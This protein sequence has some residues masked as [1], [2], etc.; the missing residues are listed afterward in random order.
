[1]KTLILLAIVSLSCLSLPSIPTN[2]IPFN[3]IIFFSIYCGPVAEDRDSFLPP[4]GKLEKL[5]WTSY[6]L[7]LNYQVH[8]ISHLI[9]SHWISSLVRCSTN[10]A[11]WDGSYALQNRIFKSMGAVRSE[12]NLLGCDKN[13]LIK[14]VGW[15][16]KGKER[17]QGCLVLWK[18]WFWYVPVCIC[19][20]WN[21]SVWSHI[22]T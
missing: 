16:R 5:T 19:I 9:S 12:I 2:N 1:M 17:E 18:F 4:P 8:W 3:F 20:N 6:L 21:L 7:P 11:F 22:M 10:L 13:C 15:K 14:M